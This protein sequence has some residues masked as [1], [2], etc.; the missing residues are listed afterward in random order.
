MLGEWRVKNE[1]L[2]PY[3]AAA[4][5]LRQRFARFQARQVPR[6]Q[7]A[8]ADALSNQAISDYRS[9]INRGL[10]TVEAAAE[11]IAAADGGGFAAKRARRQ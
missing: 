4:T 3:H 7:N 10:W 5:A 8:V 1:G 11:A 9:G 6:A 2:R